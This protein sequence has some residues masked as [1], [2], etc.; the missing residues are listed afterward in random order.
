VPGQGSAPNSQTAPATPATTAPQAPSPA[1]VSGDQPKTKAAK[2]KRHFK[3]NAKVPANCPPAASSTSAVEA[4]A[5]SGAPGPGA[6]TPN[7]ASSGAPSTANCPPEK[8]IIHNGGTTEPPIQLLGGPGGAQA[9]HQR[10]TTDQLLGSVENN[11]KQV[12][13]RQL[14]TA[15]QEMVN[16]IQQ[17]IQQSKTAVAAGD[18]ERGHNLA[19]KAHLLSEELVKPQ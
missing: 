10:D 4:T 19:M 7:Q 12:S 1:Q 15:Q 17:F 16:Q 6:S 2:R 11:L 9:S 5:A 18:M 13:G 3:K 8:K 14:S